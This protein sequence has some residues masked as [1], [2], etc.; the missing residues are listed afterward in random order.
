MEWK[1]T[2]VYDGDTV[3]AQGYGVEIKVRLAGIDA[4]ET[5]KK[6]HR[7]SQPYSEK[8]KE[9]L[10]GLVLNRFVE[11]EG[12]G[13]EP[14]NRQLAVLRV[15]NKMVNLEMVKAGLAEVYRGK[16]PRGFDL[17]PYQLAEAEAVKAGRGMWSLGPGKYISPKD[18][19]QSRQKD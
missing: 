13:I 9:L 8:A 6:K 4:P 7:E 3:K 5:G 12:Y 16:P 19:R 10:A 11:L 15:N 18:W 2:R 1:I 17:R 14:Y